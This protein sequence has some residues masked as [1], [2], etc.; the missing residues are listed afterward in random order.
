[1]IAQILHCTRNL[2]SCSARREKGKFTFSTY[3][4]FRTYH[5]LGDAFERVV[6]GRLQDPGLENGLNKFKI[7]YHYHEIINLCLRKLRNQFFRK[8]HFILTYFVYNITTAIA[9]GINN[10]IIRLSPFT[11]GI[12]DVHYFLLKVYQ[13]RNLTQESHPEREKWEFSSEV[14]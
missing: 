14:V 5:L 4:P 7:I 3:T 10:K 2:S 6:S 9:E 12:N 1:M 8:W 11:Y 13:C